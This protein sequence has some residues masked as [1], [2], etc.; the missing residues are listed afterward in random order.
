MLLRG[1]GHLCRLA[2]IFRGQGQLQRGEH[3][4]YHP[5]ITVLWQ[6][7]AWNNTQT[8]LDYDKLVLVP[9]MKNAGVGEGRLG[10]EVEG[11]AFSDNLT[12][13]KYTL[14]RSTNKNTT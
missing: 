11:L 3:S 2:V 14:N 8:Q 7:K 5:D 6:A 10:F 9:E 12:A 4:S 13:H 1:D